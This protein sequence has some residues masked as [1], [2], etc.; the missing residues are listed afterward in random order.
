[1]HYVCVAFVVVVI[2][3]GQKL[4]AGGEAQRRC[5]RRSGGGT[6]WLNMSIHTERTGTGKSQLQLK[7]PS[8]CF[9]K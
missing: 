6:S 2:G 7:P 8:F 9:L 5:G 4:A 3:K 1:M